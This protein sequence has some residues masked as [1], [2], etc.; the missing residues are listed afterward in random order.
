MCGW[1]TLLLGALG[2]ASLLGKQKKPP[3]PPSPVVPATPAP[4]A[5]AGGAT[6]R[7]GGDTPAE[8]DAAVAEYMDFTE[9]RSSGKTLGGLGRSGLGL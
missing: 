1:E 4:T 3:T 2:G 9:K 5:R 8:E 7:V 6:V